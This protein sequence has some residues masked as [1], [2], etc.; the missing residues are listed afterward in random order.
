MFVV[1]V[2][3][4]LQASCTPTGGYPNYYGITSSIR[5]IVSVVFGSINNWNVVN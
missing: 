1:S 2:V 5:P 3:N 4:I